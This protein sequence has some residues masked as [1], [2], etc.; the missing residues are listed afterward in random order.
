M[1]WRPICWPATG[2]LAA[3]GA[4]AKRLSPHAEIGF[5]V[6]R[7]ARRRSMPARPSW[8][9]DGK[10][11]AIEGAEGTDAMLQRVA[12]LA[13]PRGG[14]RRA[15]G[16]L[17]KG[18][19]PGQ[20]LRVDMP[21]IGPRTVEQAA[22]AGL[23][24][25]VVESRRRAGPRSAR[26]PCAAPM[27]APAPS[28]ASP[29]GIA[30]KRAAGAAGSSAR[31][32]GRV[33]P[34][35]RDAGDIETG[36]AIG[37]RGLP[38]SPPAAARGR[39]P[40]RAGHRGGRGHGRHARA[41]V[42][43]LRQW[44]CAGASRRAFVRPACARAGRGG[45]SALAALLQQAALAGSGRHGRERARPVARDAT[46]AARAADDSWPFPGDVRDWLG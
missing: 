38:P 26:K 40:L 17:A 34:S 33:R 32:I 10:V 36:L 18:P 3:I 25:I 41:R 21:A 2:D 6:R 7:S 35:Q 46:E 31:L 4:A 12:A 44:G 5:A 30:R 9:R 28:T 11:L 27:R 8:W 37:R 24:G 16:V 13:R 45:C 42:R 19:K 29:P 14:G 1:M 22:A 20:E 43:G 23:A 39:A 15:Q